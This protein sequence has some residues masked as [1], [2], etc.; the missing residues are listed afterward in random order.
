[1]HLTLPKIV[2]VS[3]VGQSVGRKHLV[4]LWVNGLEQLFG[5]LVQE[6]LVTEL[7]LGGV[8]LAATQQVFSWTWITRHV[9]SSPI[10]DAPPTLVPLVQLVFQLWLQLVVFDDLM[11][12]ER[13]D[14]RVVIEFREHK[15]EPRAFRGGL[16]ELHATQQ[17]RLL[18]APQQR[19]H[20]HN[21]HDGRNNPRQVQQHRN[22]CA[23][24]VWLVPPIPSRNTG[25]EVHFLPKDVQDG[26]AA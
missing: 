19:D 10:D 17:Y 2:D 15:E 6:H 1:M 11:E 22:R 13:E 4:R 12:G 9:W 25:E 16:E 20:R 26:I 23:N 14:V 24:L 5:P 18:G 8:S 21:H 3:L 7:N